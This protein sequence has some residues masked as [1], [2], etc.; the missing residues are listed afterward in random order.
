MVVDGG[1]LLM[2]GGS[3]GVAVVLE[4]TAGATAVAVASCVL[5][6]GAGAVGDLECSM[7]KL[8][9]AIPSKS[10]RRISGISRFFFI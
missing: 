6:A 8:K 9:A 4:L 5:A 2:T 3:A 1:K 10:K 7:T